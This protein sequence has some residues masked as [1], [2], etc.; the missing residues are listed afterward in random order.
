MNAQNVTIN[1]GGTNK[2]LRVYDSASNTYTEIKEYN[3][4]QECTERP[5][6]EIPLHA[7]GCRSVD[8]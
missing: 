2:F 6:P 1:W 5:S 3:L 4:D 8:E 7:K